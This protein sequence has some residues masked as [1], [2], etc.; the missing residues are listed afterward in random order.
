MNSAANES[1]L[2]EFLWC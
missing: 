2:R 1:P